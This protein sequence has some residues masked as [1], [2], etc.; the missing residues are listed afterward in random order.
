M[1][2]K[3]DYCTARAA[4]VIEYVGA[5]KRRRY[6]AACARHEVSSE[7]KI[8]LETMPQSARA[9]RPGGEPASWAA[10]ALVLAGGCA[11]QGGGSDP[12]GPN[13][14]P[15]AGIV[16]PDASAATLSQTASTSAGAGEFCNGP[17]AV[18]DN[19]WL[20]AFPISAPFHIDWILYAV[21]DAQAQDATALVFDYTG[22][23][24]GAELSPPA[25]RELAGFAIPSTTAQHEG[26]GVAVDMDMS[27]PFVIGIV[28]TDAQSS[29]GVRTAWFHLAANAAGETEPSYY[30]SNACGVMVPTAEAGT[31]DSLIAVQ[32]R[33][34]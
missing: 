11:F 7:W 9:S 32:G 25:M 23:I 3:C 10:I 16:A 18:L 6:I 14:G 1:K 34:L 22:P 12:N 5:H 24:G 27:G 26:G 13:D 28:S 21:S 15:D 30:Q 31:V 20:R 2:T 8:A 4:I 19:M 17:G 33:W 29:P